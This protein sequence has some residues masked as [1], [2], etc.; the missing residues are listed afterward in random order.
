ME[1]FNASNGWFEK[2]KRSTGIHS[3]V[4]QGEASSSDT[5]AA[6]DFVKKFGKIVEDEVYVE[7]QIFNCDKTGLFWK[8]KPSRTH[9]TAEEKKIP[10]HKPMK[11]WLTPALCANVSG[12]CKIEPLLVYHSEHPWA[13]KAH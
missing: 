10:G 12:D 13:F 9:I 6:N 8:K 7:Q 2:F 3:I 5:K 4:Q 1:E 11:D